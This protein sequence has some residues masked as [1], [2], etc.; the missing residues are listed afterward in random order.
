MKKQRIDRLVHQVLERHLAPIDMSERE[1]AV[2]AL[3]AFT[4]SGVAVLYDDG[5]WHFRQIGRAMPGTWDGAFLGKYNVYVTDY[6]E[7]AY[8]LG[9]LTEKQAGRWRRWYRN[10]LGRWKRKNA[11]R[12]LENLAREHGYRLVER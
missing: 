11:H 2:R 9:L 7:A 5:R 10:A 6:V 1:G 3:V 8:A 4:D 12:Q